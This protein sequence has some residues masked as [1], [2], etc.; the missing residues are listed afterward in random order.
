MGDGLDRVAGA[1]LT[2]PLDDDS[3]RLLREAALVAVSGFDDEG[4][5]IYSGDF[6][7][8]QLLLF[9]SGVGEGDYRP[10]GVAPD[11]ITGEHDVEWRECTKPVLSERD[12]ICALVDE[13]LRLRGEVPQ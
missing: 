3:L 5:R 4:G 8:D 10:L 7:L 1:P 11:P 12:V 13:V 9:W 6:T 2:L